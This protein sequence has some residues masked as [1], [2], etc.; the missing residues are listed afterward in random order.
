MAVNAYIRF[1]G[2]CREAVEFYAQVFGLEKPKIMTFGESPSDPEYPMPEEAKELVM[3]TFLIISG[4]RVMFS[5]NVP[6][7]PFVAG[8]NISLAI[9]GND[10][11][12]IKSYYHKLEVGGTVVMEIQETFWSKCYGML[13]DKFG[14]EWQFSHESEEM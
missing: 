9:V 13:T 12:E 7:M 8:N 6:G 11:D 4:S 10:V 2:N 3:H 5:D 14:I 1:N